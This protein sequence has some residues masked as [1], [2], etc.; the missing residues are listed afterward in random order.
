MVS[1]SY[2]DGRST[3]VRQ[4][5][6]SVVGDD[7]TVSGED[8]DFQVPFASVKI[9]ERLGRAPRRLRF[10]DGSFCEVRDLEA[11][12]TLLSST[13]HRDGPVDR[14][15]RH[16][17]SVLVACIACVAVVIFAYKVV[18]P[19]AAE[20]GA[21]HLP[22]A[23]GRTLSEQA[24]KT[25]DRGILLPSKLPVERQRALTRRFHELQ[26]PE[27][28]EL[29]SKLLFRSS[30][31]LGA[32]AFTLP[33]G[34]IIMLDELVT[35]IDDD[36]QIMAVAT[37]ELGHAHGHHGLQLLL[38]STAVG[39]F[40]SIYVGDISQLLAAAP[41]AVVQARYSQDLERE[42]D[43][44]GASVLIRN[45]MSPELLAQVLRK[46]TK[47]HPAASKGGY[48]ASHPS[49]E[50]RIRHLHVLAASH[51]SSAVAAENPR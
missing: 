47:A 51:S 40:W 24:L 23:V 22:P 31:Q 34:T 38:R 26:L 10:Q 1:A 14:M 46:L 2:F 13:A 19:W 30:P 44:F 36:Q 6:L 39:A 7:L 41:A 28:D 9:D 5:S 33:D 27:N 15:Q 4:V 20:R 49:T 16:L 3:R 50:D 25:L 21:S 12:D 8:V 32:N 11:L 35:S 43:D 42:A 17:K 45:H 18:L 37:H 48:L 29:D